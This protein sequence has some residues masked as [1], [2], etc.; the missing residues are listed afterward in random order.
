MNRLNSLLSIA[1][2]V[3]GAALIAANAS[4]QEVAEAPGRLV[5]VGPGSV[6]VEIP[7]E[8][9]AAA[10]RAE[11]RA[12]RQARRAGGVA[13][14]R[15]WI[16]VSLAPVPESLRAHVDLPAGEG[17]MIQAVTPGGPA[18]DAGVEP[19]DLVALVDDRPADAAAIVDAVGRAGEAGESL[20]LEVLRRGERVLLTVTP[21]ERPIGAD[22]FAPARRGPGGGL[23]DGLGGFPMPQG[24]L[25]GEG[26]FGEGGF[27]VE[28]LAERA[29][30]EGGFAQGLPQMA[31]GGV[32]VRVTQPAGGPAMVTVERGDERWEFESGDADAIAA[33]PDDIR[34]MVERMLAGGARPG[35][36]ALGVDGGAFQL[37][38]GGPL[39]ERVRLLQ[40]RL[41]GM[42]G[43][44]F[45]GPAGNGP[46]IAPGDE[47]RM[48]QPFAPEGAL[49]EAPAFNPGAGAAATGPVE[50]EVPEEIPAPTPAEVEAIEEIEPLIVE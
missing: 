27:D 31:M 28:G 20:S 7:A 29:F 30:G 32:S 35:F 4:G 37:Q 48:G 25:D 8:R 3:A 6:E 14:A 33:L 11:R 2:G 50:I 18:A 10:R 15:Y 45:G 41:R 9:P 13:V 42:Q 24:L 47:I 43:G 34:P 21:T 1:G 46:A 17:T 44:L 23:R 16:G 36:D 40:E 19:F 22:P 12:D 38:F 49:D 39:G 5:R 26:L